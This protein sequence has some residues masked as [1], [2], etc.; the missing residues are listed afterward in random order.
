MSSRDIAGG[1]GRAADLLA[2]RGQADQRVSPLGRCAADRRQ[3]RPRAAGRGRKLPRLGA[4]HSRGHDHDSHRDVHHPSRCG[5]PAL[6]RPARR[7]CARGREGPRACTT[8]SAAAGARSSDCFVRWWRPAARRA[9]SIRPDWPRRSRGRRGTI[10][11]TSAWMA[12]SRTSAV[13]AWDRCGTAA[14]NGTRIRGATRAWNSSARPRPTASRGS[15]TAGRFAGGH[16]DTGPEN[17]TTAWCRGAGDVDVRLIYTEPFT[18]AMLR[19]D[20]LVTAM[21]RTRLWIADAYF[22]GHGPYV[23]RAATGRAARASTCDCC[24]RKAATS[25]GRCPCRARCTAR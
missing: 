16:M 8:G 7:T 17:R 24:C 4:G 15:P 20:L 25:A 23:Q 14:P 10:A 11:S 5:R 18:A 12:A 22:V 1:F 2:L 13:C 3:P 6:H 9:C 19:V 21:A